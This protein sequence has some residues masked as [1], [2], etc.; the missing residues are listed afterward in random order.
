[1]IPPAECLSLINTTHG[2][3]ALKFSHDDVAFGHG[4]C[5]DSYGNGEHCNAWIPGAG[6]LAVPQT[7]DPY[8]PTSGVLKLDQMDWDSE[9]MLV[10]PPTA[11]RH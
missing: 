10:T 6:T 8:D 9:Q 5:A 11:S 3:K 2:F 4:L 7:T 1:M